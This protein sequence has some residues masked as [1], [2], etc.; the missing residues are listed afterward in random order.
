MI[1]D[2][3]K[4]VRVA[5]PDISD[6]AVGPDVTY[7]CTATAANSYANSLE[8]LWRHNEV[9]VDVTRNSNKYSTSVPSRESSMGLTR[10]TVELT[11]RSPGL[12]DSGTVQC[13][14]R[15]PPRVDTNNME[16]RATADTT[17]SVLGGLS[18]NCMIT[19][20]VVLLSLSLEELFHHTICIPEIHTLV[21]TSATHDPVDLQNHKVV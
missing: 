11:I 18:L 5:L 10:V 15:I 2:L 20:Y 9:L 8:L 1:I 3:P 16:S 19:L 17:L 21:S 7:S 6:P 12:S 13:I 14:A 4:P